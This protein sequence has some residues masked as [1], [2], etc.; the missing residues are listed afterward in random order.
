VLGSGVGW[1][2]SVN[3]AVLVYLGFG[4]RCKLVRCVVMIGEVLPCAV[5]FIRRLGLGGRRLVV[6]R[7]VGVREKSPVL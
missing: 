3:L 5:G 7:A 1:R 2:C 4:T 6:K